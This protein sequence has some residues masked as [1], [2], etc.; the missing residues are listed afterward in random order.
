MNKVQLIIFTP[1]TE[2]TLRKQ[3]N[4]NLIRQLPTATTN[5]EQ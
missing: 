5:S 3:N 2:H 1:I 4:T